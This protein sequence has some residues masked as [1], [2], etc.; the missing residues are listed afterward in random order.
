MRKIKFFGFILSLCILITCFP[1]RVKAAA[2]YPERLYS[3][4]CALMDGDSGRVLF[5][6]EETTPLANASTT[7]IMTCI[8]ALELGDPDSVVVASRNAAI[9]PKVHLGM[10]EG[11]QFYLE[12]LLHAMMLES[13]NDTAVAIAEHIAGSTEEFA[14]LMNEKAASLGCEDTYF[15][16]PNGLDATDD[17][18]MH[19]TTAADLCRIMKYCVWDSP[20]AE[21]F[22]SITECRTYD[23]SNLD[24]KTYR[25]TNR[26]SF[27]DMMDGVISGKTGF[28]AT[29]GYCYVAAYEQNG[30]KFCI[31]ILACGWPNNKNY[32]WADAKK[33]FTYGIENY[34]KRK[35][36]VEQKLNKILVKD[37]MAE[38]SIHAWKKD[39]Y[40]EPEVDFEEYSFEYLLSEEDQIRVEVNQETVLMAPVEQGQQLGTINVRLNEEII[41]EIPIINQKEIPKWSLWEFEKC[42]FKAY[43]L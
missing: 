16:T 12:D 42:I 7:K 11:E 20:K 9:Q 43:W 14:K 23:F 36:N 10:T 40:I 4:S 38:R 37:G 25:C 17:N 6:K 29:A 1:Y 26:N 32:K 2:D 30:K 27:L 35:I 19:H 3:K 28:T 24:G 34:E 33:L 18:G 5:G 15:I 21:K 31:S 39:F 41:L 22:L 13:Y 8:L